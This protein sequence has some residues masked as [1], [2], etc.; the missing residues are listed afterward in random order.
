MKWEQFDASWLI[1]LMKEQASEEKDVIKNLEECK[2]YFKKNNAYY[3]FVIKNPEQ[4]I[5]RNIILNSKKY[6][7][8][9][10]DILNGNKIGGIEFID[11]I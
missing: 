5:E 7:E 11:R 8:I 2:R 1:E 10:L 4:Y 3:Y 9:V 6:G